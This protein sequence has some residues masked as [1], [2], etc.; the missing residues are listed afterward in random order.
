MFFACPRPSDF[1]EAA[2]QPDRRLFPGLFEADGQPLRYEQLGQPDL[3]R[4]FSAIPIPLSIMA[5][6]TSDAFSATPIPPGTVSYRYTVGGC[7]PVVNVPMSCRSHST[8]KSAPTRSSCSTPNKL[9]NSSLPSTTEV[10]VSSSHHPL[11]SDLR[12]SC[13]L[14]SRTTSPGRTSISLNP[15][16]FSYTVNRPK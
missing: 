15:S 3:P 5:G 11:T 12:A 9:H 1:Q 8:T 16:T 7:L 6:H 4:H 2:C 13:R 14:F 10:S